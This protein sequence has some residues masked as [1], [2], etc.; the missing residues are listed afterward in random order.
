MSN[1]LLPPWPFYDKSQ[2][3]AASSVL[4]SGRVNHW[5]GNITTQ[6]ESQFSEFIGTSHS[7]SVANGSLAL[8]SAYLALGLGAGDEIITTPRTF[9]ATSSS[10]VLLGIKPVFADVCPISGA[11]HPASIE[12]LITKRTRAIVVV[13]LGGWPANMPAIMDLARSYNLHVIEDCAQSHGAMIGSNSVGSF[14]DISVWSFCQDKIISTGGEGGMISTNSAE[15]ADIIWSFRDHGKSREAVFNRA[16]PPGFR[17]LHEGFGSNFR[18]T[19]FQSAIGS[20][21]LSML[22]EWT[23]TR[24]RNASVLAEELSKFSSLD[25]PLPGPDITHAWYKFYCFL[26][27]TVLSDGWDRD[28][29]VAEISSF[30]FPAFSGSCSE[31]YLERCF[32]EAGLAPLERLPVARSLGETSL[33]FLVHPTIDLHSM[34]Q[35]ASCISSVLK[36]ALL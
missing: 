7:L 14:G 16:H 34:N 27:P 12:P 35:Y 18:L 13:H 17:W 20:I 36:R 33:M 30:G 15:L 5:T 19:E 32:Q 23:L 28:R 24:S 3:E 4:E 31:I 21:Q 22:K 26:D 10:A 29:I 25:I 2:I 9:I 11:I 1:N 8:S 6:F